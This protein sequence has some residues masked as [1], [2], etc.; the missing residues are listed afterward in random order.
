MAS[1]EEGL[2]REITRSFVNGEKAVYLDIFKQSGGNTVEVSR[3]VKEAIKTINETLE[4]RGLKSSIELMRDGARPIDLNLQD[5]KESIVIG[6]ILCIIVV[7][8][9]LGSVRSTFITGMA[10]PNSLLGAFLLMYLSGFSLNIMTLLSLSLAVGLLIDDAIV[11][12]ENIF[13]YLEKGLD[14][15]EAAEKGTNEVSVAVIATTLVVI[16]VFGPIAFMSGIIGQFFKE[17]G[18]TMVYAV[19]ISLFDALTMAP[20]MS[21]YLASA[22]EHRKRTGPVGAMLNAFDAF[23]TRLENLYERILHFTLDRPKTILASTAIF[24]LLSLGLVKFI[25]KTFLPAADNG[26]FEVRAELKPGSNLEA[27]T[28]FVQKIDALLRKHPEVSATGSTV[29]TK[30]EESN[31]GTIYV[32]LVPKKNRKLTTSTLKDDVRDELAS[33]SAEGRILVTDFDAFGGGIRPFN[34]NIKGEDLDQLSDYVELIKTKMEKIPGLVDL[35][36]NYRKGKPEFHVRFDRQKSEALGVSTVTAGSELRARVEGLIPATFRVNGN[37]FNV[38]VGL[39]EA[40]QDLKA[41]FATTNV[42]NVNFNMIPLSRVAIGIE[43]TGYSQINRQE[44]AR[45]IQISG[46]I[47]KGGALNTIME[48]TEVILKENPMPKGLSWDFYGQAQDFKELIENFLFAV[49][50]GILFIYLVLSSLYESFIT[51]L[52]IL[53]ALPFAMSGAFISLL[54]GG[55]R[56]DIFAMIGIVMLLGVVAKNSILLVDY[57]NQLMLEGKNRRDSLLIAGRTR[58]RPILM[59]SFALIAGMIPIAIGLNEA[60]SQRTS[61]GIALIG[62]L[63]S[64][65]LLTLIVVPA[66]FGYVDDLR[67]ATDRLIRRFQGRKPDAR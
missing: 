67:L 38:R 49:S 2:E 58:L 29:G 35:D 15:K 53:L 44:R 62:G 45:Y 46:D 57:T 18:L 12:R 52:T 11:V 34:L 50:L 31:K 41:Q 3:L 5:V 1:V 6:I 8:F 24:F 65:T 63:I 55:S 28:V 48:H 56:L 26:E 14:P 20:M 51:P 22:S 43:T 59:T 7:F 36:T 16:S 27:T 42:P 25:P 9:F 21:A 23:Q 60:S 66:A 19:L 64:S 13:R 32:R 40:G 4:E 61:M 37:E 54:I 10:L 30:N 47:G 39:N 17:F 33:L